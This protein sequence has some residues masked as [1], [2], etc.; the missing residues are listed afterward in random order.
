MLTGDFNSVVDPALDRSSSRQ[1]L[2]ASYD[3]PGEITELL[4]SCRLQDSWRY[5]HPQAFAS[6][7]IFPDGLAKSRIDLVCVPLRFCPF[8]RSA[9]IVPCPHSDHAAVLADFDV[10][11]A[12]QRGPGVWKLN[13]SLLEDENYLSLIK[14]F[15]VF[16]QRQKAFF[17]SPLVWW[18]VGKQRIK[19]LSIKFSKEK[20]SRRVSFR[21]A[22]ECR[23]KI[24][25][26][27]LD[28]GQHDYLPEYHDLLSSLARDDH[29][30]TKAA[31]VRS[32]LRWMEEGEQSSSF[33]L[34]LEKQS[35]GKCLIDVIQ[36]SIDRLV[37]DIDEMLHVW[38]EF[39]SKL[40]SR[41][42]TD[43]VSHDPFLD[44]LERRLSSAASLSCEGFL[45]VEE[46]FSALTSMSSNKTPGIDGL[47]KEFYTVFWEP[48][49]SGS[50][51]SLK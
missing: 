20:S 40:F 32:R 50:C 2:H 44:C 14:D 27:F 37:S 25:K 18:D 17:P 35:K 11:P 6:S 36:D 9:E 15:W 30:A 24:V 47:P 48:S 26:R 46:C 43:E 29:E 1:A 8:L 23:V 13:T 51:P 34:R 3:C 39:Y 38:R 21:K 7:Y 22:L 42:Q 16:W 31:F 5:K 10:A 12:Q 28:A 33:F 4:S 45:T 19:V 49:W 41:E